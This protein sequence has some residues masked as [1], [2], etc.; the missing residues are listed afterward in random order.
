MRKSPAL[1]VYGTLEEQKSRH[2]A[3]SEVRMTN[4]LDISHHSYHYRVQTGASVA[5]CGHILI[6]SHVHREEG[7]SLLVTELYI[8][9][10]SGPCVSY[11]NLYKT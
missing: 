7:S 11:Y 6:H 5:S 8:L 9:T 2:I 4:I 3:A 10:Q 1:F